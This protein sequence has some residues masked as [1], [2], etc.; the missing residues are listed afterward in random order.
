MPEGLVKPEN[1]LALRYLRSRKRSGLLS[2]LSVTSVIGVMLGVAALIIVVNV[3]SGFSDNLK[4]KL[5]GANSDI[6]ITRFDNRPVDNYSALREKIISSHGVLAASPF[7]MGQVLLTS[8]KSVTGVVIKGIDPVF[9][10][11]VSRLSSFMVSGA[12]SDLS[13]NFGAD[14]S[15]PGVLLGRDLAVTLGVSSGSEITVVSPYGSRGPLGITPKMK[16]FIVAGLFD[17]GIYEYNSTMAYI[18]VPAAQDFLNMKGTVSGFSVAASDKSNL[19]PIVDTL[20]KELA[21]P[22]WVRDWLSMNASLFS[23]L[24]LE[25]FAMFVILTLIIVV[26]SF[27]IVSMIAITVK[28]KLKDIAILRASGAGSGFIM[29]VFMRQGL[30]VGLTGTALGDILALAISLCLKNFKII[31]LPRDVYFMDKIPVNL[32]W[33]VYLLVTVCSVAITFLAAIFPARNAA[34]MSPIEALRSD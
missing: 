32:D 23:A 13:K 6:I 20:S 2:F 28:D 17:T 7:I 25:Q 11:D 33:Q 27:N 21:F 10:K 30:I 34:K 24:K 5:I 15:I 4:S 12:L 8:D 1:L 31:E 16:K 26:A 14:N 18:S 22:Y 19:M 9:E 3:M 29:S